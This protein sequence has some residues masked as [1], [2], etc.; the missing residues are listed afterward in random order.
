MLLRARCDLKIESA[1]RVTANLFL[2]RFT[3]ARPMFCKGVDILF[4]LL[5]VV[6]ELDGALCFGLNG[7]LFRVSLLLFGAL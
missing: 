1:A 4:V 3:N 5:R 7:L 2:G 6:D